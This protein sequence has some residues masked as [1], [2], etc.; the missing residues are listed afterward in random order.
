MLQIFLIVRMLDQK[1]L[2]T[3]GIADIGKGIRAVIQ[4]NLMCCLP[5]QRYPGRNLTYTLIIYEIY[6][7]KLVLPV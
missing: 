7:K 1:C 6:N 2:E 4:S 5:G 3:I